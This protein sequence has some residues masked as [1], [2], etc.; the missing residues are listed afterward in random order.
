M[1]KVVLVTGAGRGLGKVIAQTLLDKGFTVYG[2][3]RTSDQSLIK[4]VEYLKLDIT[5]DE[6]CERIINRIITKENIVD[7]LVNCAGVS[8]SGPTLEYTADDFKRIFDINTIGAFRLIKLLS[9]HGLSLVI[10]ITSLNGF[11]SLPNFGLYAASKFAI[12][13]LGTA[14]R[15]ELS[16]SI[17]VVNVAPGALLNENSA[18]KFVHKP[19]RNKFPFL[20]KIIPLT[21]MSTVA[22]VIVGLIDKKKVPGRVII[23]RDA[24]IINLLQKILPAGVLDRLFLFL[25]EKK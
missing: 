9:K 3:Y 5:S 24:K 20:N 15:Y 11:L 12:E 10:N 2:T 1:K 22:K 7:V 14:L 13:A 19:V 6:E 16:P 17:K 23:G 8:I 4:G 21:K 18:N 25:W